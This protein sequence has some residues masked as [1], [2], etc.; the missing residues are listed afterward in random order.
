MED[1]TKAQNWKYYE[2]SRHQIEILNQRQGE[3]DDKIDK[4][5]MTLASGSFGLSFAFI[6]QIVPMAEATHAAL[7]I[8][9]WSC[10]LAVL[11]LEII[12]FMMSSFCHSLLAQQEN[13]I[14]ELKYQGIEPEYKKR[15]IFFSA[16]ALLGY[17]SILLFI[18]GSLCLVLFIAKNL[19]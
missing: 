10:F 6:N 4:W 19:L 15:S 3:E 14:L 2:A 17:V 18:G 13:K 12:A 11:I 9:A 16:N 7:L 5:L 1:E 8:A